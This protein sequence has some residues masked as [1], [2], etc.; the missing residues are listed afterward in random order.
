M[1]VLAA[2]LT[3]VPERLHGQMKAWRGDLLALDR[4]QRL[5]YFRHPKAGSL[6]FVHPDMDVLERWM[7]SGPVHLAADEADD[8]GVPG[9]VPPRRPGD[10]A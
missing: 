5:L 2:E 7:E 10:W 3:G 1:G 4:R 6:E 8:A 9:P